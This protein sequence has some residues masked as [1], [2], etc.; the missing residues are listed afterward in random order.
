[1]RRSRFR[2]SEVATT[3]RDGDKPGK[4]S[5]NDDDDNKEAK[6]VA[7]GHREARVVAGGHKEAKGYWEVTA[8]II[9]Y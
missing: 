7:E 1:V 8:G 9:D 2:H 3:H 4:N 5:D 6:A